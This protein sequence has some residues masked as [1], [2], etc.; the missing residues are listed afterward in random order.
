MMMM[1]PLSYWTPNQ[2]IKAMLGAQ[3]NMRMPRFWQVS[4]LDVLHNWTEVGC[5]KQGQNN[6]L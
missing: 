2:A 6:C 4:F 5:V 3:E 1:V